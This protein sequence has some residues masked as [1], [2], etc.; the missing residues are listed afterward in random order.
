MK[1]LIQYLLT[2]LF[3]LF[4]G[5]WFLTFIVRE[6]QDPA[7]AT[8]NTTASTE[9]LTTEF[10]AKGTLLFAET[11]GS[12]APYIAYT[13]DSNFYVTKFLD[14]DANSTCNGVPCAM[15]SEA[16]SG[17]SVQVIGSIDNE[18]VEVNTLTQITS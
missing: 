4:V 1:E 8:R 5:G 12:P 9:I 7:I 17:E 15:P 11:N 13:N 6:N 16:L 10:N 2:A 18:H 14:F 3:V